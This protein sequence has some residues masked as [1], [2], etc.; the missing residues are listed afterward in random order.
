MVEEPQEIN[1]LFKE[2]YSTN[3]P[4]IDVELQQKQ[5]HQ[6]KKSVSP[7]SEKS[8]VNNRKLTTRQQSF[9]RGTASSMAKVARTEKS[10][11][12]VVT[13]A[14]RRLSV[15]PRKASLT[16]S[17]IDTN[18]MLTMGSTSPT[19]IMAQRRSS[20][21]PFT[22]QHTSNEATVPAPS[23][24]NRNENKLPSSPSPSPP[25]PLPSSAIKM[26]DPSSK[27]IVYH[28]DAEVVTP[29]PQDRS[30]VNASK[31][32]KENFSSESN[33]NRITSV[34][35]NSTV[36]KSP[37][38]SVPGGVIL[39]DDAAS[40]EESLKQHTNPLETTSSLAPNGVADEVHTTNK[41]ENSTR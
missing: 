23:S 9:T 4:D 14:K 11:V 16:P 36:L 28:R 33:N 41:I 35:D 39:I 7:G 29:P 5:Q 15:R 18:R 8:N 19:Q 32:D 37:S 38:K 12:E 26:E 24:N 27:P 30:I 20:W 17:V 1:N 3:S 13:L 40:A 22:Q 21:S 2:D 6:R 34:T 31:N 25:P 10:P